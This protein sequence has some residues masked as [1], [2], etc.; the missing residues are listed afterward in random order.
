VT[1]KNFSRPRSGVAWL[2]EWFPVVAEAQA[3]AKGE[4][5]NFSS[6]FNSRMIRGLIEKGFR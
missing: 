4:Y 1:L 5:V 6:L 3:K 2:R